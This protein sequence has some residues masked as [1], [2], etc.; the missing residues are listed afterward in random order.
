MRGCYRAYR[1]A[2][3]A[4]SWDGMAKDGRGHATWSASLL[5][6]GVVD[7]V[8]RGAIFN[9][10]CGRN[11]RRDSCGTILEAI[12]VRSWHVQSVVEAF[13]GFHPQMM[14]I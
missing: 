13:G 12:V 6:G 10:L 14:S 8:L 7:K 11:R 4:V 3:R 9:V 1:G 5:R 2:W